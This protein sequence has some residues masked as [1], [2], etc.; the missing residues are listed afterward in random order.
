MYALIL[1]SL[2]FCGTCLENVTSKAEVEQ[3]L[4]ERKNAINENN[5]LSFSHSIVLDKEE[6]RVDSLIKE[7]VSTLQREYLTSDFFPAKRDF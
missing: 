1:L 4:Q 6:E 2:I 7:M 3:Y 5:E